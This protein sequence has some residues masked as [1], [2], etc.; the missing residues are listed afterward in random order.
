MTVKWNGCTSEKRDL[1]GGGPQGSN[2]GGLE[3]EVNSNDNADHVTPDMRFKFVDDLST[4]EKLKLLAIGLSSYNFKA[5]VASDI[6]INQKYLPPENFLGQS[7]LNTVEKWTETNLMKLNVEKTNIMVFNFTK[8][9][10][11]SSRLYLGD[12]LIETID[13]TKLLGTIITSDLKW[14][15]NSDMLVKKAYARMQM[16]QKLKSFGVSRE[17]LVHIYILYIRSILELNC[18]VWHFSLTSEDESTIER[19]Q[20]V[21][22]YLILHQEYKS[23]ENALKLVN[24][25][26]LKSRRNALSLKFAKKSLKHPKASQMFPLNTSIDNNLRSR[27]KFYVQPAKTDRLLHSAIPQLQRALNLDQFKH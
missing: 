9:Y 24:L 20:K 1:P 27:E 25:S 12:K 23:Y 17:D 15:K 22:L 16:I 5:H 4:L 11:F 2:L 14:A 10:Q 18:Q 3:F 19:V 21:A 7:S 8:E 26:T 13:E 6:G